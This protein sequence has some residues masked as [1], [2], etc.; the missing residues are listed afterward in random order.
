MERL[1]GL[2][3]E[4][5]NTLEASLEQEAQRSKGAMA[6][7]HVQFRGEAGKRGAHAQRLGKNI[8]GI[9]R[10]YSTWRPTR[11]AEPQRRKKLGV[12][13]GARH[14]ERMEGEHQPRGQKA[15]VRQ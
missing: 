11:D 12:Q 15:A 14:L 7:L 4:R 5:M 13:T 3:A 6:G 2:Q 8:E 1:V 10:A 9:E